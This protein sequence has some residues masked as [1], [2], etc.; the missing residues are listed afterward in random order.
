MVLLKKKQHV[1][2]QKTLR[3]AVTSAKKTFLD[4]SK[5]FANMGKRKKLKGSFLKGDFNIRNLH[6][7]AKENK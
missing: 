7:R 5:N 1:K 6:K 4:T 3:D 2:I